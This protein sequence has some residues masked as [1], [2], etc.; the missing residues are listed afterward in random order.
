ML[1]VL[2]CIFGW[3]SQQV[4]PT[5]AN[6]SGQRREV[7]T[8]VDDDDTLSLSQSTQRSQSRSQPNNSQLQVPQAGGTFDIGLRGYYVLTSYRSISMSISTF[9][10]HD[11]YSC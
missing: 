7:V 11:P 6:S 3:N 10:F 4:E 8:I 5:H 2:V 9:D 1:G